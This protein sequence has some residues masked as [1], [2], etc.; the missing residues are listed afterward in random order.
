[1][2]SVGRI[3]VA[4]GLPPEVRRFVSDATEAAHVPG[5]RVAEADLHI[6][7]RFLGD[8]G[9]VDY[10]RLLM[11]LDEQTWPAPFSLRLTSLGAFPNARSATVAW[12]G[13]EE[14]E[15]LLETHARVEDACSGAGLGREERPFR[16]HVTVARIRPPADTRSV[17][18]RSDYL[19]ASFP[20]TRIVVLRSQLGGYGP[21]YEPLDFIDL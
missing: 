3:F 9:E 21:R 19:G 20:V 14:S 11:E 7:L 6:T 4:L 2:E 5:R 1:M 13:V 15:P 10:D 17:L 8:V 12:V 16:P 18:A